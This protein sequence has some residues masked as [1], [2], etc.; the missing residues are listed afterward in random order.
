MWFALALSA[1]AFV[2]SYKHRNKVIVLRELFNNP[3]I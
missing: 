3:K 2:S 1:L